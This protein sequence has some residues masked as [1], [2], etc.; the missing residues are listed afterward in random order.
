MKKDV[1]K[2]F[3]KHLW[4]S[5]TEEN[6]TATKNENQV[7]ISKMQMDIHVQMYQK[8]HI[9]EE[10]SNQTDMKNEKRIHADARDT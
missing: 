8:R 7:S 1:K 6:N 9:A 4:R 10:L 5:D 3:D 2:P